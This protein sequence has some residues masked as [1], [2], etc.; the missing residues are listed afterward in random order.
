MQ[1]VK[2]FKDTLFETNQA[3]FE[4]KALTLFRF[5]AEANPLYASYLMHLKRHPAQ[6]ERLADV[7]FLPIEFFK[8]HSVRSTSLPAQVVFESSSTTGQIPSRHLVAD[9]ALYQTLSRR[10]F[11]QHYG[12]LEDY[13]FLALLPAY[14]ERQHSSLVY[15]INHF[16]ECAASPFSGYYLYDYPALIRQV[17]SLQKHNSEKRKIML[18]G[19]TFALLDLAE[20]YQLDWQELTVVETGGMKGR[21]QE[22]TRAE[23]HATL[24]E[25]LGL[26]QIGAEYGM[27]ELLSQAYASAEGFFEV[28]FSMQ[29]Y[30]RELNDPFSLHREPGRSGAINI[31]D[32]GNVDSCA[33][34]ETKD[35]GRLL[36]DGRFEVLGR[37]DNA[38]IR[39]C[40]LL[41]L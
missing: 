19:V 7:P 38:D 31:V 6:I 37:I 15:M 12:P 18:W 23:L 20:A 39:G 24:K 1:F 11:E 35:I 13:H 5:Q 3:N 25:R 41:A 27:T 36:P 14:L 29:I 16:M 33:F 4:Q 22:L 40:S 26:R 34:I 32:L 28:P 21:R 10:I 8:S 9:T 30:L 2:E 17:E